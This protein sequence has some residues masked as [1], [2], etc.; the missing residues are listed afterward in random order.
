VLICQLSVVGN[1]SEGNE[2]IYSLTVCEANTTFAY[3]LNLPYAYL[4]IT[5]LPQIAL[6]FNSSL[7]PTPH[8]ALVIILIDTSN[9]LTS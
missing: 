9:D 7:L 5:S 6:S 8:S 2:C 1:L 4:L 3:L